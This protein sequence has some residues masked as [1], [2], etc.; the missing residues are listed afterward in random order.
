MTKINWEEIY[1]KEF[2]FFDECYKTCDGYCCKNFHQSFK[3]LPKN[4]VTL[5]LLKSEF[6]HY[7]KIGGI[8]NLIK[9]PK[10]QKYTLK[11]GKCLEIVYLSCDCNGLCS[12]HKNRPLICKIYPYF[13]IF[14]NLGKLEGFEYSS[15]YD[16]FYKPENHPCTLVSKNKL[17]LEEQLIKSVQILGDFVLLIFIFK[18]LKILANSLR[19]Y[20]K[21][22][23]LSLLDESEKQKFFT[24]FEWAILSAKAWKKEKVRDDIQNAY[25]ELALIYGDFL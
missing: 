9:P 17:E 23:D 3:I 13:P 8:S 16:L 21:I 7:Q 24:K 14:D 22:D 2:A 11:N 15:I 12:P 4:I 6:E 1:S 18:V 20:I 25:D 10:I 5:P 19:E